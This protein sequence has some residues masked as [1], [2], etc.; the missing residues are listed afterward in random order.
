M[1]TI[2][3]LNK[4]NSIK[5]K[6]TKFMAALLLLITIFSAC[7][8]DQVI[9]ANS[10]KAENIEIGSANNKQALKGRDFHF[11]ADVLAGDKIKAVQLKIVQKSSEQYTANWKLELAWDEYIGAKNTNVHK[12][13]TIPAEAPDGKY[14]FYFIVLDENGTKLELKEELI[15]SDPA[16]MPVDPKIGR[17]MISRNETLIYYMDTWV[18]QELIFKKGDELTAH[19]QISEIKGD[20]ILYTVLI[21]KSA[22]Y[23]PESIDKLDF[24]KAIVISKVEH[25]NLPAASKITTLKQVNG[26]YGGEKITIG[27]SLDGNEPAAN[28][29][30]G[31]KAWESGKYNLVILYKNTSYNMN[32]FK[33][34]PVTINYQ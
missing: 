20:G 2:K 17:D 13:F 29:I 26:V 24:S 5:M 6:T 27:A 1:N 3:N 15:I 21:R 25:K 12:H 19:A 34:I 11:N 33:V 28:P 22:N 10:P 31:G 30:T 7:K 23:Y 8:K 18:E 9:E 4:N 32:V 14:D 16:N